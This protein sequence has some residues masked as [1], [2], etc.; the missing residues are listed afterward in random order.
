LKRLLRVVLLVAVLSSA[1]VFAQEARH[2][3]ARHEGAAAAESSAEKPGMNL[4]KWANF[5]IL[6]GV[7]GTL[8]AKQ[9]GPLLRAR[10]EGIRA[11]L[12]A[13]E[14]AK[15]DAETRAKTVEA[16][17]ASLGRE[18]EEM[19]A[20]ARDEQAR[21]AE[22]IRR[23]TAN[24]LDR[25]RQHAEQEI[26]AAGKQARIEVQRFA[27]K[28]AIDLAEQKVRARMSPDAQSALLENFVSG[29]RSGAPRAHST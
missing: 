2:E 16:K 22:R 27:A 18:I 9:A 10:S 3:I 11:G 21:E 19:R 28:L 15:L 26:E 5:A 25:I 20:K 12:A 14:K 24:E 13:G 8:A 1:S 7:L 6:F 29:L 17:L 4:W 23:E